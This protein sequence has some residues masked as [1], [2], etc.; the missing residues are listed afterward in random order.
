MREIPLE[1]TSQFFKPSNDTARVTVGAR[2]DVKTLKFRKAEERNCN[3][4][5]VTF[6][7]FDRNGN[8]VTGQ[9]KV[10]DMKL[11]DETL[12]RPSLGIVV[13]SA[14]DIK[15][16]VYLIRVVVRD[17]EGQSMSALNGAADIP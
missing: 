10:V 14:L 13:R 15:P 11:K 6:G 9:Q 3:K 8:Y 12:T 17:E 16:G 7:L 5:T 2:I 1:V 4:R